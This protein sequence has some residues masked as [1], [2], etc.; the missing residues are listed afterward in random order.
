MRV[1]CC[2][3]LGLSFAVTAY[4]DPTAEE[5]AF[6]SV[7]GAEWRYTNTVPRVFRAS[8]LP[9]AL[10]KQLEGYDWGTHDNHLPDQFQGFTLDLNK[11]GKREYFIETIY[12]GSG[13]PAY[14]ILT[15]KGKGWQVIGDYQ[16]VLHVMPVDTGWAKLV[17]TGRGGGGIYS[18]TCHEF[19]DGK[20]EETLLEMY[21]RGKVTRET[22]VP[23]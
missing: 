18:K 2:L 14:M 15:Q 19:R 4:G 11:D 23:K 17:T 22:L 21:E 8:E 16:G 20:Y 10:L 3:A 6:L 12:G 7:S 9:A 1:I 5:E 13:G